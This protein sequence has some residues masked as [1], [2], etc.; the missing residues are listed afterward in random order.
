MICLY[1]LCEES[2][3]EVTFTILYM[4]WQVE[5]PDWLK[6]RIRVIGMMKPTTGSWLDLS[7]PS[8]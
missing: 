3:Q 4:I 2:R 8:R 6:C 1:R 5:V 7:Q